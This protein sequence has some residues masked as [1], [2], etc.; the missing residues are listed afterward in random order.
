MDYTKCDLHVHTHLSLCGARDAFAEDYLKSA[1][2]NGVE[3]IG[4][5]N[6][7][8]DETVFHPKLTGFYTPQN[9]EHVL[10]LKNELETI[11]HHGVKVLF[12]CETE[13]AGHILGISEEKAKLFDYVVVPHSH[14]HM[15]GFVLPEDVTTT[16]DHSKYL[17]E[18]FLEVASHPLAENYIFG[19]VHPFS[20]VGAPFDESIEILSHIADDAFRECG[21]AAKKNGVKIELNS[22]ALVGKPK[23][24]I[25]ELKR[26]YRACVA[27]GCEFFAGSDKHRVNNDALNDPFFKLN[28]VAD[29]LLN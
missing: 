5:A 11:S 28:E 9:T 26:F 1:S 8:W 22:S 20:P 12:G 10:K 18:S 17:V 27:E 15:K 3:T 16:L 6:H 13:Y 2:Q 7:Y 14:T 4:F 25:D 21:K 23:E 24:L 29:Y 19:I